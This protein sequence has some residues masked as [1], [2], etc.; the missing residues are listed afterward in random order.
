[1]KKTIELEDHEWGQILDGLICRAELYE[2]TVSYYEGDAPVE[3]VAEVSGVE[4]ARAL[5]EM[6]RSLIGTMHRQLKH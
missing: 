4:E 3:A 1:M 2:N 6:Y 5:A